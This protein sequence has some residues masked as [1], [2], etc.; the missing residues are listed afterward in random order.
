[1]KK[2]KAQECFSESLLGLVFVCDTRRVSWEFYV[3]KK[4]KKGSWILCSE[5][6]FLGG[7][8]G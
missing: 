7:E 3:K 2:C 1:M 5:K 6:S 8:E 4:G